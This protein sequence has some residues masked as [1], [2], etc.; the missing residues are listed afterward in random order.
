MI[1]KVVIRNLK[2]FQEQTFAGLG[3]LHLLVG[4][5]NSGKSTLLQA[6]AIWNKQVEGEE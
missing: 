6:L 2:R 1:T 3:S 4:Q 5:N